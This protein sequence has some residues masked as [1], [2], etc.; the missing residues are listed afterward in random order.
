MASWEP[1]P[2]NRIDPLP[3]VRA[4]R[5]PPGGRRELGLF[6]WLFCKLAARVW[7]VP[8]FHLFTVLAQQRRLFWSWA[9]FSG[10]LLHLGRLPKRD[11]EVVILRV[12][13]L[14][15]C[16]YELQQHRRLALRR[17]VGADT[18]AKVFAWPSAD[19]LS[20]RQRT[21]LTGVDELIATRTVTDASWQSL[22]GHLDRRQLIEFVTLVGQYDALAMTLNTL[23]VPMDYP[24]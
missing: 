19:G 24:D 16:E 6:G 23:G 17:G 22:A 9:P 4:P 15:G 20:E 18:Q 14:R 13:H 8:E 1:L 3:A 10:V 5:I 21:L 11:A 2:A 7:G 12:G